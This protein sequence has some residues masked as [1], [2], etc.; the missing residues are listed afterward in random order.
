[1]AARGH[2]AGRRWVVVGAL[3]VTLIA[4]PP[5]LRLLPASDRDVSAAEL[6]TR[7]LA[8]EALGFSGYAVSA[9]SLAL[10]V[11]EQLS[12]VADLFS[13]RTSMR[14]WWR[15]AHGACRSPRP[16]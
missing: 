8:T 10:P 13:S 9:G 2:G 5:L 3:V 14:V 1:M 16:G 7:A 4:L 15:R 6:R 11:T 12:T